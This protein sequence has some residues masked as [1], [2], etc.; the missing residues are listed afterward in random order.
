LKAILKHVAKTV[1][2]VG[3]SDHAVEVVYDLFDEDGNLSLADFL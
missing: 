3:L 2:G 1:A